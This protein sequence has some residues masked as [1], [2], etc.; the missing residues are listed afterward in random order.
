M[1]L[2]TDERLARAEV[3]LARQERL[4]LKEPEQ[5]LRQLAW[6]LRAAGQDAL[7][8][9]GRRQEQAESDLARLDPLA[10]LERGYALV[11]DAQGHFIRSVHDARA[12][13]AAEIL[14]RDGALAARIEAIRS[15]EPEDASF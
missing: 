3:F 7:E 9:A 2:R 10:P 14:V 12:G 4:L 6:R 15:K 13:D 8:R 1:L 5:R 11:R